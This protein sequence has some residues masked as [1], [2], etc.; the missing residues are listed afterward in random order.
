MNQVLRP[1]LVIL[2]LSFSLALVPHLT[3]PYEP[4]VVT[5][6]RLN[7]YQYGTPTATPGAESLPWF[8]GG[9]TGGLDWTTEPPWTLFLGTPQDPAHS[10]QFAWTDSPILPYGNN[11]N[12]ALYTPFLD[13]SPVIGS[14]TL[15]FWLQYQLEPDRDF[16]YVEYNLDGQGWETLASITGSSDEYVPFD[17]VISIPFDATRLR[18]RFRLVT[19]SLGVR[20][21]V[22]LDDVRVFGNEPTPTNTRTGGETPTATATRSATSTATVRATTP[23]TATPTR[24][25]TGTSTRAPTRTPTLAPSRTGTAAV[26]ST[27]TRFPA[28]TMTAT[29]QTTG[30]ATLS[31]TVLAT[32]SGTATPVRT[33]TRTARSVQLYL[34]LIRATE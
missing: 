30:T 3:L 8:D 12:A 27:A 20:D 17:E 29:R 11:V 5:A 13:V 15:G 31:P 34:P 1:I 6:R 25:L 28:P 32:P 22:H 18:I 7:Q 24:V 21:G 4:L 2:I 10:G 33:P 19:N 9:E 14:V 16:L 26:T 23:P